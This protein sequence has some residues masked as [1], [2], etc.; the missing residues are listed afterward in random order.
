MKI[1]LLLLLIS[2]SAFATISYKASYKSYDGQTNWKC[3]VKLEN[4]LAK[5]YGIFC[6]DQFG[7]LQRNYSAHIMLS[8]Y[9]TRTMPYNRYELLYWITDR[10]SHQPASTTI[11]FNTTEHSQM[12]SANVSLGVDGDIAGLY[13][14]VLVQ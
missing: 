9:V 6:Y 4:D 8:K 13:L 12:H 14:E 11:W 3:D 7:V 1:I 2:T 5:N 10:K